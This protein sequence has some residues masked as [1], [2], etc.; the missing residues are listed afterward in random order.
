[1]SR[2]SE[3]ETDNRWPKTPGLGAVVRRQ[4]ALLDRQDGKSNPRP[5]A[6]PNS[7]CLT[8]FHVTWKIEVYADNPEHAARLAWEIMRKP[9]SMADVFDVLAEGQEA[10]RVDL[11]EIDIERASA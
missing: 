4:I 6:A 5:S 10:V 7:H 9:D 2:E 8:E 3:Y 1:M 11:T